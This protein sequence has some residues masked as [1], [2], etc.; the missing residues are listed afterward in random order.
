LALA[1]QQNPQITQ[2]GRFQ[3][4]DVDKYMNISTEQTNSIKQ[5]ITIQLTLSVTASFT[6]ETNIPTVQNKC[7]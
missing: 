4:A 2:K 1:T 6:S 7:K 5:N 3:I